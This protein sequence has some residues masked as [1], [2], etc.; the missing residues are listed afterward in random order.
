MQDSNLFQLV[1]SLLQDMVSFVPNLLGAILIIIIGWFIARIV[2]K[3]LKKLIRSAGIDTL[4]E[5][6]EK[7]DIIHKS[8][9]T[10]KPSGIL[11]SLFYYVMMLIFVVAAT[12]VL[13]MPAISAL[14]SDVLTY[15]P[16]LIVAILIMGIGLLISDF[17][18]NITETACKSIGISAHRLIA[19]VVFYFTFINVLILALSQ[20]GI[21]TAFLK[22]NLSIILAGIIFA[23]ALGYGIASKDIASNFLASFYLKNKFKIGD[24]ITVGN[25]TGEVVEFDSNYIKLKSQNSIQLVPIIKLIKESV[26]I[27]D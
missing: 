8:G 25:I 6:I 5:Q 19:N 16:N 17:F 20:A 7:I 15:A 26:E 3:V 21:D 10:V 22:N 2:R 12:D 18:K 23:F 27:H 24:N 1:Q 13:G 11:S 4:G 9:I 14:M